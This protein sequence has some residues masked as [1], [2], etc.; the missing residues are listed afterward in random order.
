[1]TGIK[2][3]SA[4][5]YQ[6][7]PNLT[8]NGDYCAWS[9][10]VSRLIDGIE[11]INDSINGDL[12]KIVITGCSYAV[13]GAFYERIA[14]TI[15]QE[16][17]GGGINS[18]RVAD[19]LGNVEKIE[20]T[21]YSWFMQYL[22]HNNGKTNLLPYDH[23]ELIGLIAPRAFLALGNLD[24]ECLGDPAGYISVMAAYEIW[25]AMGIEDRF[26]FNFDSGIIVVLLVPKMKQL[27]NML[28]SL[29]EEKMGN[30]Y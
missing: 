5:F 20:N 18:W 16:S 7:Y 11:Q 4:P 15:V 10:G 29:L 2:D 8:D 26:G 9:W 21:N 1:M 14:L 27:R 3:T 30:K 12:S 13:S 17:G 23:L 22:K 6:M 24:F 19:T 25:K 28:I